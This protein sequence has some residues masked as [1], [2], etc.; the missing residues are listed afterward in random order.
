MR[1]KDVKK[2]IVQPDPI[3]KSRVVTRFV[4]KVMLDGKK[5]TAEGIVFKALSRISPDAKEA[6]AV[7][8]LAVKNIMPRQEVRS[9]R[10]GGATYQIPYP[11]RHDRAE[12]LA[13]RWI[14]DTSRK[15][16]GKDMDQKLYEEITNAHK[17]IG[18]SIKKRD[19]T[20]KMAEANRAF[21]HFRL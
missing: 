4:N 8:E 19:D 11:L 17:G 13:I 5:S 10:I 3:F 12:A 20:H 2:R 1:G 9:R 18:D 15:R 21:A 6:A 7:F 16:K 14:V